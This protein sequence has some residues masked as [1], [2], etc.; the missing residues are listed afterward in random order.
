MKGRDLFAERR[1]AATAAIPGLR[2]DVRRRE[3]EDRHRSRLPRSYLRAGLWLRLDLERTLA[4]TSDP[5]LA[6]FENNVG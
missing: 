1:Q 6:E 4:V 3:P 5:H 2:V